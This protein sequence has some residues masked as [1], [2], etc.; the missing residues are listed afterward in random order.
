MTSMDQLLN[1]RALIPVGLLEIHSE[2]LLVVLPGSVTL[3]ELL[4]AHKATCSHS[5]SVVPLAGVLVLLVL[6]RVPEVLI[7]KLVS[8]SLL[9]MLARAPSVL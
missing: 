2:T 1:S 8:T 9:W 7:S 4:G 6:T 3:V 5:S